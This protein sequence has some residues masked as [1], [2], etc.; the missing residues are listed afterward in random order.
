[1]ALTWT[2]PKTFNWTFLTFWTIYLGLLAT[3]GYILL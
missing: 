2:T 3:A 1:M